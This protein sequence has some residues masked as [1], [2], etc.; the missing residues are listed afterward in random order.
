MKCILK[1][2]RCNRHKFR[3]GIHLTEQ[4]FNFQNIRKITFVTEVQNQINIADVG[5]FKRYKS[6]IDKQLGNWIEQNGWTHARRKPMKLIKF[7]LDIEEGSLV[8]R[9]VGPSNYR[10]VPNNRKYVLEGLSA[11]AAVRL[12]DEINDI[13][14]CCFEM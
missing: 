14:T 4:E 9:C 2:I 12:E 13:W 10:K 5:S 6:I 11:K 1:V 7:N 3:F 8:F